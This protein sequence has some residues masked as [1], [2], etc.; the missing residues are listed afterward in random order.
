[1][2]ILFIRG[3]KYV[4]FSTIYSKIQKK[5]KP[6]YA[7]IRRKILSNKMIHPRENKI[8]DFWKKICL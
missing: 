1:M 3:I 6:P 7:P 8:P 5:K 4:V 2:F